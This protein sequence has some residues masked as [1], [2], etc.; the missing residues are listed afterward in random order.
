[1]RQLGNSSVKVSDQILGCW[2]MGG[3]YWGGAEDKDSIRAIMKAYE[4]NINTFDTAYVYGNG[5]SERVLGEAVKSL[6]REDLTIITKLWKTEMEKEKVR[7]AC[8]NSLR[9]L[10]MDYLDVYF[11][12]YPSDE[13][14]PIGETM[15]EMMK[16][17]DRGTIRSIGL[18]NFSLEQMKEALKYGDIDVIQP[19]YSLVWREIDQD[20]ILD[21]CVENN[22]GI[23]PYSTLAQGILTGKFNEDTVFDSEDGRSRAPIFQE[24]YYKGALEVADGLKPFAEKYDKTIAQIAIN[25][26]MGKE[27]ITAPIVG[28][29]NS[30]QAG[31]NLKASGWALEKEDWDRIDAFSKEY[32][33]KLPK[34][35]SFFDATI[36]G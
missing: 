7:P 13:G 26:T 11:I 21:Y 32:A 10:Q 24:E 19:C 22:I 5:R 28:A 36:I 8:E 14:V 15:E 31:E 9:E 12:H 23:I 6:P 29:R 34:F 3:S 25:W 18:S 35:R 2:V 1:M 27:G 4:G 33:Y 16:L 30:R 20:G 17:K